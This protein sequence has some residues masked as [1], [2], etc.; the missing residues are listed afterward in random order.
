MYVKGVFSSSLLTVWLLAISERTGTHRRYE[1]RQGQ[2]KQH[3]CGSKPTLDFRKAF[4]VSEAGSHGH[5]GGGEA[6]PAVIYATSCTGEE[7]ARGLGG[8]T[9]AG[10][11]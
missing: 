1:Q 9:P 3:A 7:W 2:Q 4:P 5:L 6:R 11:P 8:I 10:Q